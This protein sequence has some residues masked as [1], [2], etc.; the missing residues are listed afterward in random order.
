VSTRRGYTLS[1]DHNTRDIFELKPVFT[2][3]PGHSNEGHSLLQFFHLA[4]QLFLY[5]CGLWLLKTTVILDNIMLGK[6]KSQGA[7]PQ[8][9]FIMNHLDC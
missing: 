2:I 4:I 6:N 7:N 5:T 3:N 1:N 9:Y 8:V